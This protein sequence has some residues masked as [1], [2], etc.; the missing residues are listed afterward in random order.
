MDDAVLQ[1]TTL[2]AIPASHRREPP[3]LPGLPLQFCQL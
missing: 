1:S 3:A 2:D